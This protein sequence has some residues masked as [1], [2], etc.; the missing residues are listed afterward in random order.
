[1]PVSVCR[2]RFLLKSLFCTWFLFV[3]L[4]SASIFCGTNRFF[5]KVTFPFS[6]F[7]CLVC[8]FCCCV[9]LCCAIC[10]PCFLF[11]VVCCPFSVICLFLFCFLYAG[12]L[13]LAAFF[14]V[15]HFLIVRCLLLFC[16]LS[17]VPHASCF[18][19]PLL[20]YVLCFCSCLMIWVFWLCYNLPLLFMFVVCSWQWY[21]SVSCDMCSV[22]CLLLLLHNFCLMCG[23]MV[24][25]GVSE[26]LCGIRYVFCFFSFDFLFYD[27]GFC[28]IFGF[29]VLLP[30]VCLQSNFCL[31]SLFMF[32]VFAFVFWVSDVCCCLCFVLL[33]VFS[34]GVLVSVFF[35]GRFLFAGSDLFAVYSSCCLCRVFRNMYY[36]FCFLIY[37]V[38]CGFR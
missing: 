16:V 25:F 34:L 7:C 31:C 32:P 18:K 10:L 30:V 29:C 12:M 22:F 1:M 14:V 21:V 11:C 9:V 27:F 5:L 36:V 38:G 23:I 28:F 2:Q 15:A 3:F 6:A 4:F 35:C 26:L 19:C 13:P 37:V 17:F 8:V 24:L 33:S 20:V